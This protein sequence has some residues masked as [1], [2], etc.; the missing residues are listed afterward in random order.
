MKRAKIKALK[1][2]TSDKGLEK[3]VTKLEFKLKNAEQGIILLK[4]KVK[5]ANK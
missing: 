5:R 2:L 4:A 1:S 3:R